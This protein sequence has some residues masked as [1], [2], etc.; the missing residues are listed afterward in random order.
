MFSCI[1]GNTTYI[2]LIGVIFAFTATILMTAFCMKKLPTDKGREYAH[3]GK[4]SAGK[5][6]GAGLFFVISF[7]A[8]ALLF[9]PIDLEMGLNL[10]LVFLCM[11]TGYLDDRA[12]NPWGELRKGVLDLLI[13]VLVAANYL[14]NHGSVLYFRLF[15]NASVK[16]PE[17]LMAVI[18]AALVWGA[19]NVTN[20]ADG[21][22]GLSATL[23][24]ITLL[25]YYVLT[26]FDGVWRENGYYLLLFC[27]C[28][29]AYLWFNA[30]PSILLMGDAGSRS[31]GIV[32][33][34]A[35]IHSRSPFLYLLL[36][37]VIMLD[38]G[39]GLI[40]VS[41]IRLFKIH[42]LNNTR[43]P[44]HDHVRKNMGWSNTHCVFRFSII[45]IMVSAIALYI[46]FIT[47]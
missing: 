17:I 26:V 16:I 30:T 29:L 7:L 1:A 12:S 25:S 40:K 32:I 43:T 23:T 46:I 42:I 11:L 33:A 14:F 3:D 2:R 38:G 10:V 5:P 19:I 34:I 8:S 47:N 41:L 44:L 18:I 45:Q 27:V 13:A 28:L 22:D 39:L 31:M 35:A 24:I 6:R 21:V 37:L 36:S 20:C 4:L 15:G 9:A